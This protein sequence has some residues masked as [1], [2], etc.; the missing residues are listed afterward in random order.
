MRADDLDVLNDLL[1]L[2]RNGGNFALN[3]GGAF[4]VLQITH[5]FLANRHHLLGALGHGATKT[6]NVLEERAVANL[7]IQPKIHRLV[8]LRALIGVIE[9]Q[10]G[11]R[12]AERLGRFAEF[13]ARTARLPREPIEQRRRGFI[14]RHDNGA[15]RPHEDVAPRF[16]GSYAAREGENVF[17]CQLKGK[18]APCLAFGAVG[19][20]HHPIADGREQAS[21]GGKIAEQ[22]AMVG[23]DDIGGL[24]LAARTVDEAGR[25]EERAFATQAIVARGGDHPARQRAV[26]DLQAVDV[27]VSRLL[28]EG[29]QGGKGRSLRFLLLPHGAH[30]GAFHNEALHLVQTGIMGEPLE[31]SIGEVGT[32]LLRKSGKLMIDQ[33]VEESVRLS[34]YADINTVISGNDGRRQKIGH[35]FAHAC[36][37]LH[38]K[39]ARSGKRI[40]HCL[41]HSHLLAALLVLFV[42]GTYYALSGERLGH[43]IGRGEQERSPWIGGDFIGIHERS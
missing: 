5:E 22:E 25:A 16:L 31:S 19:L 37:C 33:L 42:Q 41:G 30:A 11:Q 10:V 20:I 29:K 6:G 36:S 34:S 3:D 32:E 35:G 43:S 4:N 40:A 28:N 2:H 26:V 1:H 8:A 38:H 23:N 39:I 7:V 9:E 18:C 13:S 17:L 27:V 12:L 24:G 15:L 21:V 14:A